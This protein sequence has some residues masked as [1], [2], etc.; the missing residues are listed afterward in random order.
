[1]IDRSKF[2]AKSRVL[3]NC[4]T[5]FVVVLILMK[6]VA[7]LFFVPLLTQ[8]FF[9]GFYPGNLPAAVGLVSTEVCSGVVVAKNK[10]LTAAHCN[11][12]G[13]FVPGN[14]IKLYRP[15]GETFIESTITGFHFHPTW[16]YQD[17][18]KTDLHGTYAD[19]AI[20]EV[21]DTGDFQSA[22]ISMKPVK[23]GEQILVGGFGCNGSG[24]FSYMSVAFK[25]VAAVNKSWFV[26]KIKDWD[27]INN[28]L[29]CP[30]DSGGAAFR[31]GSAS[32]AFE[33]IG[34]NWLT[35]TPPEMVLID[36]QTGKIVYQEKFEKSQLLVTRFE[37]LKV[38]EWLLKYLP[39]ESISY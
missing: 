22:K 17:V 33:V 18:N 12:S 13:A 26:L 16:K 20:L 28:S 31:V 25:S 3:E 32:R 5:E 35:N 14:P 11:L 30:G 2:F 34:I 39:E 19:L 29:F 15:D 23:S 24:L 9:G 38:R 21:S 1:M 27:G 6:F 7:F 8:A 10:I 36:P 4:G 37:H